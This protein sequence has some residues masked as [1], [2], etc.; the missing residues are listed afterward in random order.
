MFVNEFFFSFSLLAYL[1]GLFL[2]GTVILIDAGRRFLNERQL[3][4]ASQKKSG[5][6]L[7]VDVPRPVANS[8]GDRAGDFVQRSVAIAEKKAS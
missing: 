8:V 3:K 2:L 5:V 7:V 4:A 6:V 1:V